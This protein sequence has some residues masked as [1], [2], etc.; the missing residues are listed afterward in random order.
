MRRLKPASKSE[1]PVLADGKLVDKVILVAPAD[2]SKKSGGEFPA[3]IRQDV[4]P[5]DAMN[6]LRLLA[7]SAPV[8]I[9][10]AC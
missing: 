9:S 2:V 1:P 4:A 8:D 10:Q 3:R 5:I 6:D 7:R